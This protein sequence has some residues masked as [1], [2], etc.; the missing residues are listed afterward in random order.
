MSTESPVP[1]LWTG[2]WDSTYRLL[3]LLLELE[4]S[5]EPWYLYDAQRASAS[6]EVRAMDRM[7][8]WLAEHHPATRARLLPTRVVRLDE[9]QPDPVIE[10]AFAQVLRVRG[11]G[12]QYAFL[13][14]FAKQFDVQGVELSLEKTIHGAHGVMHEFVG[15]ARDAHGL[16]TYRVEDAH[17]RTPI[18]TIFGGFSLPLF[19]TD[20]LETLAHVRESGWNDVMAMTWFCHSPT[21]DGRPCGFCN[22]CQYAIQDGFAWRIPQRRRALSALFGKTLQPLRGKTRQWLRRLRA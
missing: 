16:D 1:L 6:M 22:P 7:R 5:V 19:N 2:G 13:A 3:V 18:G 15:R 12:D 11:I 14:R 9:V 21:R 4:R 10:A 20:K 8:A 17:L